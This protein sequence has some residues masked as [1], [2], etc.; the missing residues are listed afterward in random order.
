MA[1]FEDADDLQKSV[2]RAFLSL[3]GTEKD[4]TNSDMLSLI[5]TSAAS[6]EVTNALFKC[7]ERAVYI[8]NGIQ[9]PFSKTLFDIPVV[10]EKAREDYYPVLMEIGKVNLQ[11][12]WKALCSVL[13][14]ITESRNVSPE[15]K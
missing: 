8:H 12:F 11:P 1:P 13:K 6:K 4:L 2:I 7:G 3:G 9:H 5:L 14:T 15:Q 10:G